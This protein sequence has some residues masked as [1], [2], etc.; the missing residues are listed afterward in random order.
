MMRKI[1]K[2]IAVMVMA[3]CVFAV[4]GC[5]GTKENKTV[6]EHTW[7]EATCTSAKTCSV[8][9]EIEGNPL[10]HTVEFGLCSRCNT[11]QGK[12]IFDE[13]SKKMDAIAQS[14]DE[15]NSIMENVYSYDD[16]LALEPVYQREK[17]LYQDI[18]DLC[19][20]HDELKT[21][22]NDVDYT[23]KCIP[24][25]VNVYDQYSLNSFVSEAEVFATAAFQANLSY[26]AVEKIFE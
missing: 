5:S 7:V 19:G 17:Q 24:D 23:I 25:E 14:E 9:G 20:E 22:K 6:H 21:L 8:C 1:K 4:A 18:Y 11:V 26:I 15:E 2:I 16:L 3:I 10:G 13:I 12:D